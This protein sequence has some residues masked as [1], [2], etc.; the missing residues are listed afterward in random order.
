MLEV[1]G[2]TV[3]PSI[4]HTILDYAKLDC[5]SS[6]SSLCF[7]FYAVLHFSNPKP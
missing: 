3:L 5:R 4:D 1:S 6:K 2:K 7:L